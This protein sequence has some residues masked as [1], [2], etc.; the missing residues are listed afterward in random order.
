MAIATK[1]LPYTIANFIN[2]VEDLKHNNMPFVTHT[3][4]DQKKFKQVLF[5]L[6]R[7]SMDTI[8]EEFRNTFNI[9][10]VSIK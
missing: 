2:A 7:I 6:P 4:V 10:P 9:E 1:I 8:Q 5:G 3:L